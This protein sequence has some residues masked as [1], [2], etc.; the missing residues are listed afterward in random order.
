MSLLSA[1]SRRPWA[2]LGMGL[3]ARRI[4]R[5]FMTTTPK[6]IAAFL[7]W[8]PTDAVTEV[9]VNGYVRSVRAQKKTHFVSLG[10]GSSLD[11][12]QAVVPADKAEGL[13]IGAAVRLHGS[14][15]PSRGRGQSHEL[16]V[17][18]ADVL[19]PSDAKTFPLQKKY[20]TPEYLR[21]M[22]HIRPRI[23]FNSALLRFRSEIITS[24]TQFFNSRQFIQ[25]HTP[26]LTSADCEGGGE[27]FD[28]SAGN[29]SSS[30]DA[31]ENTH[32]FRRPVY[33]TVS[34]QLH[35]EALAQAVGNV[36]TLSPTFRAEQSDTPRHLS[37]FYMLEAEMSFTDH[38]ESVMDLVEDMLRHVGTALADSKVVK[39]LSTRT[40]EGASDLAPAEEVAARWRGLQSKSWPRITY[41]EAIEI[42]QNSNESFSQKPQWGQDLQTEHEKFLAAHVGKGEAPVFITNYP[43]SIKAFYMKSNGDSTENSTLGETVECF[44]L[45]VPEFCEIAGGSMREHRLQNLLDSMKQHGMR[46]SYDDA[47]PNEATAD[48]S[49]GNLDWYLDLRQWGCPPHGGFGIGFD[50]LV[51]YLSGVQTIRDTAAFPRWHGRCDC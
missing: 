8:K 40:A 6:T 29:Q 26:I 10:D 42:L 4:P 49:G 43:R 12:L 19:G 46:T 31:N 38:L 16:Q 24:L 28:I 47:D 5:A 11:L 34:A 1:S 50:R 15:T 39:E 22:P 18:H 45:L 2:K 44:D 33:T 36:W 7:E 23:P 48:T 17:Q 14:W 32:F 30:S 13:T 27:V 41:T 35:L 21:T 9:Q 37:E 51:C 20:Q 25:T 3:L